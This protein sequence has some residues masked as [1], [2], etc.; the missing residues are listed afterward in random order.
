MI[1]IDKIE[2][3]TYLIITNIPQILQEEVKVQRL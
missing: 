1:I 2:Q 3:L